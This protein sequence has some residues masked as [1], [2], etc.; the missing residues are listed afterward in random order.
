MRDRFL[1]LT[2]ALSQGVHERDE[3][4]KLGLLALVAGESLFLLGPPGTA[5]SLVARRL[6]AA[7]SGA[8]AFEYLMGRFSTPEEI[9]GP[10]SIAGLRDRDVFERR[11]AGYLPEADVAFLDEVW[12]ASPPIQ[13][14]LLTILNEKRFRNGDHETRVPLKL[15]VAA[16]NRAPAGEENAEAF[17]DRFVVRLEV[18]PLTTDEGF[19]GLV[20]DTSDLYQPRVAEGDAL[21]A[22]EWETL[23]LAID[24]VETPDGVVQALATLRRSLAED[25]QPIAVSDRRWKKAARLLRACAV[26]HGRAYVDGQD[27]GLLEHVLWDR[28]EQR[29]AVAALLTRTLEEEGWAGP[30]SVESYEAEVEAL[31]ADLRALTLKERTLTRPKPVLQDGEY[32]SLVGYPGELSARV[33]AQDHQ[34]LKTDEELDGELFFFTPYGPFRHSE[35]HTLRG[36]GA[37]AEVEVDGR[38][39]ALESQPEQVTVFDK[40]PPDGPRLKAWEA[41]ARDL[42]ARLTSARQRVDAE[43]ELRGAEAQQHLFCAPYGAP[44]GRGLERDSA[45]L[46]DLLVTLETLVET[47]DP[48]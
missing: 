6:K 48:D 27:L 12:R 28:P 36:T 22:Q 47:R 32:F 30:E 19:R 8:R 17:W 16:S 46:G 18:A 11:T 4:L 37:P 20:T 3:A 40:I 34:L 14:T 29:G 38:L 42:A 15:L 13:N 43:A 31:R 2:A 7:L 26:A 1:R 35:K 33:W 24:L 45:D 25:A 44:C 39:F 5:K 21:T 23:Q 9:F 41:H 10:L